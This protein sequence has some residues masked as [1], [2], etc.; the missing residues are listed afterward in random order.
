[1]WQKLLEYILISIAICATGISFLSLFVRIIPRSFFS[2]NLFL[3]KTYSVEEHFYRLIKIKDWKEKIPEMGSTAG[4]PKNKVLEPR[5]NK[6]LKRFLE[7]NCIAEFIHLFSIIIATAI[8]AYLPKQF[9][10]TIGIPVFLVNAYFNILPLMVQRYL[11]PKL[12]RLYK[13]SQAIVLEKICNE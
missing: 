13:K 5:N 8:F 10:L 1:M 2:Y 3:F 6:Y 11:R 4:F 12:I 7:E 9:H